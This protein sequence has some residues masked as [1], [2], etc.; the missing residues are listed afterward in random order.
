MN[1]VHLADNLVLT[2]DPSFQY[3]KANG[4]SSAITARK[5]RLRAGYARLY[6]RQLYF[7]EDL[8][9]DG[10]TLDTVELYAPS[11]TVTHRYTLTSSLRWDIQRA[12]SVRLSYAHDYGRHR[13]TG[14]VGYLLPTATPRTP[15]PINDP[16]PAGNGDASSRSATASRSP[17]WIRFRPN[18]AASSSTTRWSSMPACRAPFFKRELTNYCFTSSAA[19]GYVDCVDRRRA[20]Y[21]DLP[22]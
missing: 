22:T 15:F 17:S 13:Q 12:R 2:V 7:G 11:Q 5:A 1:S 16:I 21:R 18:I 6:R 9:G 4:G 8:N 10:D 3:V 14:E 20:A 19:A